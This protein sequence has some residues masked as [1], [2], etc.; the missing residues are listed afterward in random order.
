MRGN[1]E[2]R[3]GAQLVKGLPNIYEAQG[4]LSSHHM[5]LAWWCMPAIPAHRKDLEGSEVQGHSW[6]YSAFEASLGYMRSYPHRPGLALLVFR[7][8]VL[9]FFQSEHKD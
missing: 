8:T 4:L 3:Y 5:N 2:G 1:I 6:L 9:C 7:T